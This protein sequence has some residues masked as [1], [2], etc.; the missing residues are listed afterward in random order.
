[1]FKIAST[2]K[3]STVEFAKRGFG[4]RKSKYQKLIDAVANMK[5]GQ[6]AIIEVDGENEKDRDKAANNVKQAIYQKIRRVDDS[7]PLS[8]VSCYIA[9]R[10]TVDGEV[11]ISKEE[12]REGNTVDEEEEVVEEVEEVELEEEDDEDSFDL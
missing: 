8:R 12:P 3:T 7:H 2:K 5:V 11:A 9:I 6:T 4:E 10:S 1:M